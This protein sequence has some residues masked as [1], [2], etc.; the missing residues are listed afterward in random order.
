V[1]L[2][3]A[4]LRVLQWGFV[5]W[6]FYECRSSPGRLPRLATRALI[7][8]VW[9]YVLDLP[10]VVLGISMSGLGLMC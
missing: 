6:V 3:L 1:Y 10:A 5:V 4:P 7:G 8:T 9:S 2:T